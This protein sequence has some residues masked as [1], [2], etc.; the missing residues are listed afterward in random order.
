MVL[1]TMPGP[2]PD[3]VSVYERLTPRRVQLLGLIASAHTTRECADAMGVSVS[4][5]ESTLADL[6]SFTGATS[7]R[8][9]ARWW[10]RERE[11]FLVWMRELAGGDSTKTPLTD[12]S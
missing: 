1:I 5:V 6:K 7:M 11:P 9:L 4:T 2:P 8:Q 12:G 10:L 3:A